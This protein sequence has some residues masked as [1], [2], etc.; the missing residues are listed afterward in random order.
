MFIVQVE[1]NNSMESSWSSGLPRRF[2]FHWIGYYYWVWR[3]VYKRSSNIE[4]YLRTLLRSSRP[5]FKL[6]NV[7]GKFAT[8]LGPACDLKSTRGKMFAATCDAISGTC[9]PRFYTSTTQISVRTESYPRTRHLGS[10]H[11][12]WRGVAPKRK[13]MGKQNFE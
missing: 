5:I 11:Y 2:V 9:Y 4:M 6:G 3:F 12:L 7:I 8:N 13:G 10:G 1:I